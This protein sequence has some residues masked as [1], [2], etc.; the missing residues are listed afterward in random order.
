MKG[1]DIGVAATVAGFFGLAVMAGPDEVKLPESYQTTF[2]NYVSVDHYGRKRV[3]K[4]W[5]NPEA[6]NTATAGESL[7]DGTVLIMEDWDALQ[8]A[9]GNLMFDDQG[10]MIPEKMT[11]NRFVMEKNATW[12]TDNE[13]WD[14][15]WYV[16]DGSPRP[17][18]SF[19]GCF[20]C[21][22]Y[23]TDRDYTFTYW[24]YVSDAAK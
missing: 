23:R 14:Y 11:G 15:A 8:D 24:K 10:R 12:S 9:D 20:S 18:A 4:M 1:L 21:H 3:R 5:V 22:A 7:P 17:E 16:A 19:D 2:V 13:D 6:H